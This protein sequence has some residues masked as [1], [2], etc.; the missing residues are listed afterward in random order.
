MISV[1]VDVDMKKTLS[2]VLVICL[3]ATLLSS[4]TFAAEDSLYR[5]ADEQGLLVY[6]T[7]ENWYNA[8]THLG[9]G[10][11][12]AALSRMR[13][14]YPDT[15][16]PFVDCDAL[17]DSQRAVV[18][19]VFQKG[20]MSG[21]GGNCFEPDRTVTRAELATLIW[22][23]LGSPEPAGAVSPYLDVDTGITWYSTP[24]VSL[25]ALG[26]L[27]PSTTG[28]FSPNTSAVGYDALDWCIAACDYLQEN[29]PAFQASALL[30]PSNATLH[31]GGTISLAAAFVP[32]NTGAAYAFSSSDESVV[33]I[34]QSAGGTVEIIG[35]K[36][37]E[38]EIT[39]SAG[40]FTLS[41]MVE[42]TSWDL[43]LFCARSRNSISYIITTNNARPAVLLAAHYNEQG[44]VTNVKAVSLELQS[45]KN[46][47]AIMDLGAGGTIKAFL[48]NTS[49]MPLCECWDS[50]S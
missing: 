18:N 19:T 42:V 33:Q 4:R 26:I 35:M 31:T 40:Q 21:I 50:S 38:A 44:Q 3:S 10:E 22:R 23:A 29:S 43:S 13:L 45:G 25:F 24:I 7:T 5:Q 37:G 39:V 41:C 15:S 9:A 20:V 34:V 48:L 6:S 12:I 16:F 46:G 27:P 17:S 8:L 1:G 47:G 32:K 30:F 36:K 2:F 28:E 49:Y 14:I 11:L